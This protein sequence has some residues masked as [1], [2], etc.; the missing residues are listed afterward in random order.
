LHERAVRVG[1]GLWLGRVR[2]EREQERPV[3]DAREH[4]PGQAIELR[5]R[6]RQGLCLDSARS[7]DESADRD[8]DDLAFREVTRL[9]FHVVLI[10]ADARTRWRDDARDALPLDHLGARHPQ[11]FDG[12]ERVASGTLAD[13]EAFALTHERSEEDGR[14]RFI[15]PEEKD[16][17]GSPEHGAVLFVSRWTS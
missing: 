17:D 14:R 2:S 15:A 9:G 16:L 10:D 5:P 11:C 7:N 8:L 13:D 3:D 12:H 1:V 4:E 6:P